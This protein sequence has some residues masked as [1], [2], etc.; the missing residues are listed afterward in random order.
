MTRFA[1]ILHKSK[2]TAFICCACHWFLCS[3]LFL[4]LFYFG[5]CLIVPYFDWEGHHSLFKTMVCIKILHNNSATGM[6]IHQQQSSFVVSVVVVVVVMLVMAAGKTGKVTV[7]IVIVYPTLPARVPLW[8]WE[9]DARQTAVCEVSSGQLIVILLQQ[10][11]SMAFDQATA[12]LGGVFAFP[13]HP[14][15]AR[16]GSNLPSIVKIAPNLVA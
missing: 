3:L 6:E 9:M 7:A 8:L 15:A 4:W 2:T 11:Q 13:T 12:S 1:T 16:S 14:L 5:H 10:W